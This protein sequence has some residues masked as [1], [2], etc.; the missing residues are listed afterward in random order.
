MPWYATSDGPDV[1]GFHVS[2]ESTQQGSTARL[3]PFR[4]CEPLR[5][6]LGCVAHVGA[7]WIYQPFRRGCC[8]FESQC[9]E[10]A[11]LCQR[12]CADVGRHKEKANLSAALDSPAA[13]SKHLPAC[14][15]KPCAVASANSSRSAAIL[16]SISPVAVSHL[17]VAPS[18][19]FNV[20]TSDCYGS[21]RQPRQHDQQGTGA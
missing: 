5:Y 2:C 11:R 21:A 9:Q 15:Q 4:G 18:H 6:H 17:V 12:C 10:T 13:I 3:S 7:V 19:L 1:K 20:S 16:H 8:K 14:C